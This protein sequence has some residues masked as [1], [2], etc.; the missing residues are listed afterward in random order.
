MLA[1]AAALA[2][3]ALL[4]L[5]GIRRGGPAPEER[6]AGIAIAREVQLTAAQFST[7]ETEP[8]RVVAFRSEQPAIGKIALNADT[9]TPV[10]SPF[11]GRV[12]RVLVGIGERVKAGQPLLAI[13]ASELVQAETDLYNAA[14]QLALARTTEKRRHAAYESHGGSLQD[15]QQAQ[16]ELA[17]A[18][19]A[20]AG[21]RNRLSILGRTP[22]QVAAMES[23]RTP[24]PVAYVLAPLDGVVTDRQVGPGQYL[25]AGGSTPVYTLGDLSSVWL[26]ADVSEQES[27][28]IE[29]GQTIEAQVPAL[30]GRVF[31]ATVTSVGPLVDP[32]THRVAVRATMANPDGRLRP[33]MFANFS[34]FTSPPSE[35]PAVPEEAIVREGAQARVW[36]VQGERALGLRVIRTGRESRGLVEVLAGLRA[37]ERVVTRGSLFIDRAAQPG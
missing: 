1:L 16:T 5:W 33:E 26:L 24:D 27:P 10:F 2:A 14:S 23:S 18:E 28:F 30:P 4:A 3:L 25:Q 35:A 15:W 34:I 20:L 22:A 32:A 13:E 37:G 21:A 17:A 12:T 36:V 6:A 29:R 8:V 11:S 19:T 31:R 7:L 9:T